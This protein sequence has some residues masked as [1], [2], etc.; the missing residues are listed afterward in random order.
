MSIPVRILPIH[1]PTSSVSIEIHPTSQNIPICIT[2]NKA[3]VIPMKYTCLIIKTGD[4]HCG[5]QF[6]VPLSS[7]EEKRYIV[8]FNERETSFYWSVCF[9][10]HPFMLLVE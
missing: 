9:S 10:K 2:S 1:C 4:N 7:W 5:S 6:I 3:L 8:F